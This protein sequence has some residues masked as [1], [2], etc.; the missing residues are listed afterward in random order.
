MAQT[1]V[2]LLFGSKRFFVVIVSLVGRVK[3]L[4]GGG[5]LKQ[6]GAEVT[7]LVEERKAALG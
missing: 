6:K 1:L 2:T 3:P 5:K 7:R 4:D